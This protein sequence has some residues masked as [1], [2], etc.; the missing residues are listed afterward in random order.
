MEMAS[1]LSPEGRSFEVVREEN[2]QAA[3]DYKCLP[4]Q[5]CRDRRHALE[6]GSPTEVLSGAVTTSAI[7]LVKNRPA[8]RV[9]K[10]LA[11]K[12]P[13]RAQVVTVDAT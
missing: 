2:E 11:R 7:S 8:H 9:L 12:R 10:W 5:Q 1:E 4:Q 3:A 6:L 13:R